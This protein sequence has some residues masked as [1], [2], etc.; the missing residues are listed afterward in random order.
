VR[1]ARGDRARARRGPRAGWTAAAAAAAATASRTKSRRVVRP[2]VLM[3]TSRGEPAG[4]GDAREGEYQ[5]TP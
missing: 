2:D 4:D 1:V 3:K 5:I